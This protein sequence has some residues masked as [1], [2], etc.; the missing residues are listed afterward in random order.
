[1]VL[2]DDNFASSAD[3]VEEGRTIDDNLRKAILFILPTNGGEALVTLFIVEA[4]KAWAR[5][6]RAHRDLR[7]PGSRP[8][9]PRCG[10]ARCA[11]PAP[12]SPRP[13]P[14]HR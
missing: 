5:R 7:A 10:C 4:E 14:C 12:P 6:R 2:A 9:S 3:A 11:S 8:A 1:M 13:R